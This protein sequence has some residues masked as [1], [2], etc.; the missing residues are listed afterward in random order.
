MSSTRSTPSVGMW[1]I[2][3]RLGDWESDSKH[4]TPNIQRSTPNSQGL[5]HLRQMFGNW[6][7]EVGR[8]ALAAKRIAYAVARAWLSCAWLSSI[9]LRSVSPLLPLHQRTIGAAT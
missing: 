9:S 7:L 1:G 2:W 4:S 5:A 8:S 3:H 6:A